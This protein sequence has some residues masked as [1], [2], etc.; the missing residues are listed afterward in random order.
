MPLSKSDQIKYF[1]KLAMDLNDEDK[2]DWW[3]LEG[4]LD[5]LKGNKMLIVP[6]Y[7]QVNT[8]EYTYYQIG[9]KDYKDFK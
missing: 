7:M 5:A 3:Y 9:Y 8:Q 6:M 4:C 1:E 2:N